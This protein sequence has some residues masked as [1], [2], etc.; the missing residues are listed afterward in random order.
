MQ[1][2]VDGACFL[3]MR[4]WGRERK[5]F[6]LFRTGWKWNVRSGNRGERGTPDTKQLG[7]MMCTNSRLQTLRLTKVQTWWKVELRLE[8][9][10]PL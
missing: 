3:S 4:K 5:T 6:E 1:T 10:G 8:R 2:A 7:G 9:R